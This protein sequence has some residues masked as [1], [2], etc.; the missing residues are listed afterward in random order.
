MY[1]THNQ[2]IFSLLH[3]SRISQKMTDFGDHPGDSRLCSG[4]REIRSE[5]LVSPA[6]PDYTALYSSFNV[7]Y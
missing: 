3:E 2:F 1:M 5:I 7:D 6:D 4:D